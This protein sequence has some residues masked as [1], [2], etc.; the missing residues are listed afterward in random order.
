MLEGP[1][2]GREDYQR[3]SAEAAQAAREPKPRQG[4]LF[5]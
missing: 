4:E 3:Q 1:L 5:E 2:M